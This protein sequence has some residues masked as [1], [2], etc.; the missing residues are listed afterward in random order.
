MDKTACKNY[1][2]WARNELIEQVGLRAFQYGITE[3]GYGEENASVIDGRVLLIEEKKQRQE[4]VEQIK[5]QGYQNTVEEVA[6]TWFNRFIALRYMEVNDYLPSHMRVFSDHNGNFAPEILKNVLFLD[7]KTLDQGKVSELLNANKTDELYRYLLLTQCN[8]L[9]PLLPEMFEK[10]DSY[11]ELLLPNNILR[12]EGVIG[13]LLR[14]IPEEDFRDAVQIIGWLYQYYNT[15]PKQEVFDGL[16]KNVKITREK[17]PAATQLFT[18]DWIVRYMVENS[19]GRLYIESKLVKLGSFLS[20]A[21]RYEKEKSLAADFGWKYY[22]PEAEQIPEV[23]EQ[24]RVQRSRTAIQ[25]PEDLSI[26]DPC[27]GS[28]HILVYAFDVLI[29]IYVTEGYTERDA[30]ELILEKNLYGL[31]I[32]RRAYQ[33]SYFALMM[34]GRQ[35]NRQIL[36]ENIEPQIYE[37][38]GY[39]EGMEY[40]SLVRVDQ[41]EPMPEKPSESLLL[42]EYETQ[43]NTWNFRRLLAK[44]YDVVVTNPPYMGSSGMGSKMSDYVK[45]NYPDSK[46]DLFA[47]FIE[48]CGQFLK[49]SG[50]QAMITQQA[51]MFLSSYEQLR[52]KIYQRDIINMAHLGTKAFDEIGGEVVQTAAFVLDAQKTMRYLSTYSRLVDFGSQD[53]K[54]VAFS[55][56]DNHFITNA[57]NFSRIPGSPVAYWASDAMLRAFERGTPLGQIAQPRQGLATTDNKK[58]LRLWHEIKFSDIRFDIPDINNANQ[59]GYKW[60]PY[61]KGGEYRKWH[62]NDDYVVD[63][64]NDGQK[65]KED[66]LK[67]YPYLKT[68][69]FVVKNTTFY[70]R[71]AITWSLISSSA[72][73]FRYKK[74]GFIFDVAGMSMFPENHGAYILAFCNTK[75][76][77]EMLKIL[78][79]TMNFQVGDIARLPLI[80][81]HAMEEFIDN[82]VHANITNSST[83]WDSFE[84]SWDFTRHP[85]I[86]GEK[87]VS[88]AFTKWDTE[89]SQRFYQLKS[90]E[91]ELN[92]IFIDIYGLQDELTPEVEEKDVTVRKADLNRDIKSLIS[93]AVGCMFGRYSLDDDGLA[94]AGGEWDES[95]YSTYIPDKDNIIPISDDDYFEDDITN[96]FVKWV[97]VAFGQEKLQENLRFIAYALKQKSGAK[98]DETHTQIADPKE[99]IRDYFLK[100]FYKDH[101]KIY[102][103]RP[104]YWL[105]DSGKKNG[106]KALIYMHRYQSDLLAR[107]RTDYVHEQQE[108]YRTQLGH[109]S[110]ALNEASGA[111]RTKL[112][113]RQNKLADQEKEIGIFE[114]K[115]HH[116]ADQNISI[117]LDDGVKQ[118]YPKFGDVLA[119][120]F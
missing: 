51:W 16:K 48:R 27:M 5:S 115:L 66:V 101:V 105:F 49:I 8:E 114:E 1:A 67:K 71:P 106:F 6:Y 15:E 98:V 9:H 43:L 31:E 65:I 85:L 72:T 39:E 102:Q 119:K 69:D 41:L 50:Y 14:D 53:E 116:L 81:D 44:K 92:R 38:T 40:G 58:Y 104:I 17:I 97:S 83:D 37:P 90:N 96:R 64:M 117:D 70:F 77:Y 32:D 19:L 34:K 35:Y 112:L 45:E 28:G 33:L 89:A 109:I 23:A 100:D 55:N 21:E 87:T 107:M 13:R 24:L 7:W 12:E 79:P 61:N 56:K 113:K 110:I 108:R 91:E 4:L 99:I 59:H 95:K 62:G 47:V 84:T 22:L 18:P 86:N 120:I 63:Y 76:V 54:E 75:I 42:P 20:E 111:E 80:I 118:N 57:D 52:I 46:S 78:A 82:I 11:T 73:A 94:Y 74:Q 10:L 93:Y 60:F 36:T 26:L 2:V 30:A 25:S 29:Q 3:D 68:P 103:K 88:D